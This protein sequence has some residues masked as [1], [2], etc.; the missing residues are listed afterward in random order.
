M[1]VTTWWV[2]TTLL[3]P[4]ILTWYRSIVDIHELGSWGI[5][6]MAIVLFVGEGIIVILSWINAFQSKEEMDLYDNKKYDFET[7]D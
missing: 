7:K 6:I 3:S 2:F 4:V 1:G 5:A